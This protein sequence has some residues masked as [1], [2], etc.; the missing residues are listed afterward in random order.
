[1]EPRGFEPLT[2]AVQRRREGLLEISRVNKTPANQHI[3]YLMLFLRF[4]DIRPG[5]CTVAAQRYP[6]EKLGSGPWGQDWEERK[7]RDMMEKERG[8]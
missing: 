3:I 4:Q 1:V 2:S 8:R 5:S 6:P 7:T